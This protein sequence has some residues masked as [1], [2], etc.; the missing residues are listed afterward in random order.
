MNDGKVHGL[1]VIQIGYGLFY[2]VGNITAIK[3][4]ENVG[5]EDPV[6]L[7]MILITLTDGQGRSSLQKLEVFY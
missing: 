4:P 1:F 7:A 3:K 2:V 6:H 5:V